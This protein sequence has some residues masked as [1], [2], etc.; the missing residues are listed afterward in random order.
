MTITLAEIVT[1]VAFMMEM[2][3]PQQ[4]RCPAIQFP[5]I[6]G[7]SPWIPTAEFAKA[8]EKSYK[9]SKLRD[10]SKDKAPT[11]GADGQ[12]IKGKPGPKVAM[13]T[14]DPAT[15]EVTIGMISTSVEA[16]AR[17][18]KAKTAAA[19]QAAERKEKQTEAETPLA[20]QSA[21]A[22]TSTG[23]KKRGSGTNGDLEPTTPVKAPK[24]DAASSP[25]QLTRTATMDIDEHGTHL[26]QHQPEGAEGTKKK[27]GKSPTTRAGTMAE[28]R[29]K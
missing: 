6:G 3:R 13:S 27:K 7:S 23:P 9:P 11:T 20:Q 24:G 21:A 4:G 25:A 16:R 19:A 17:A 29:A 2:D 15:L 12:I 10:P 28:I 1:R 14:E 5:L 26:P 22:T 8:G 18:A